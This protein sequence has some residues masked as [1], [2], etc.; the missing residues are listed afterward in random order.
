[1]SAIHKRLY[2]GMKCEFMLMSEA[3]ATYLPPEY[4][5]DIVGGERQIFKQDFD[6]RIDIITYC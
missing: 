4:P 1:M 2:Q 5:Y 3:F 6:Q